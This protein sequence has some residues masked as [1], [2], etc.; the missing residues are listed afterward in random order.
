MEV[1]QLD[2]QLQKGWDIQSK[3]HLFL[4]K[5]YFQT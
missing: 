2:K 4:L 3:F 5:P 1:N